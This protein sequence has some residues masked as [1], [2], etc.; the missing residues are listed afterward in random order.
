[1]D[2]FNKE[3]LPLIMQKRDFGKRSQSKWTHLKNEDTTNWDSPWFQ[4]KSKEV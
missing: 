2:K 3:T 1:M 4:E